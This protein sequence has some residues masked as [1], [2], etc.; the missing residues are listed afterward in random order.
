MSSMFW[1][2]TACLDTFLV[3]W[4]ANTGK[5]YKGKGDNI[6]FWKFFLL[7]KLIF[8][9]WGKLV[10]CII[11]HACSILRKQNALEVISTTLNNCMVKE[12]TVKDITT[13]GF[14]FFFSSLTNKPNFLLC[15]TLFGPRGSSITTL[16]KSK[17]T[18]VG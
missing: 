12:I 2:K 7:F 13:Q 18:T 5:L 8:S 1:D 4:H 6:D 14:L 9:P 15:P 10:L 3:I 11:D 17:Y 16:V